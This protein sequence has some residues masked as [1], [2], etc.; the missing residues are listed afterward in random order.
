MWHAWGRKMLARF[1]WRNL[2]IGDHLEDLTID[3]RL[4]IKWIL[5]LYA[6]RAL[7]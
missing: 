5:K 1:C 2:K 6:G 7:D 4:T 3:W